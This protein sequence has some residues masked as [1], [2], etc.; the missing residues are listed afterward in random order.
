M[1]NTRVELCA[2]KDAVKILNA[3]PRMMQLEL[4]KLLGITVQTAA[5][6]IET[7]REN[8][9]KESQAQKDLTNNLC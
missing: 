7:H 3:H 8:K 4:S 5:V 2:W 9:K 6:F 1:L